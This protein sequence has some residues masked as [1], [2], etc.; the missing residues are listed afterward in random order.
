M[1]KHA[2]DRVLGGS[3]RWRLKRWRPS[4][5]DNDLG[6]DGVVILSNKERKTA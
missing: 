6:F 4:F 3:K 1:Y 5:K 2:Y